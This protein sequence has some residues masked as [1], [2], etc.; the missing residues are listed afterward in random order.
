MRA[1]TLIGRQPD[2]DTACGNTLGRCN[3]PVVEIK[4]GSANEATNRGITVPPSVLFSVR[5]SHGMRGFC[6]VRPRVT[7]EIQTP[8]AGGFAAMGCSKHERC[9]SA[10]QYECQLRGEGGTDAQ[11]QS[12][13][14]IDTE[15][16]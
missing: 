14:L 8:S 10:R 16:W 6:L 1:T 3:I 4:T 7:P 11:C 5:L 2:A 15:A 9:L 13:A 12:L